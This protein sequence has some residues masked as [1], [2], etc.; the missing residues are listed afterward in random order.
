M[1][2]LSLSICFYADGKSGEV[3][4]TILELHSKTALQR[5]PEQLN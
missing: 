1:K 2:I 3:I 5:S 4:K